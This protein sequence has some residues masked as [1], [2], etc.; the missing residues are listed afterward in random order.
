MERARAASIGL[1]AAAGVLLSGCISR[2][3]MV[4]RHQ[5]ACKS[6]GFTPGTEPYAYCLLQLD[7]GDQGY[8]HHGRRGWNRGRAMPLP[9]PPRTQQ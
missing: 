3:E 2:Q 7:V 6:Y 8:G 1:I 9:P 4:R 5:S